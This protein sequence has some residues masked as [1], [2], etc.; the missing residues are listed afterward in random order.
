LSDWSDH[1]VL[2][3]MSRRGEDLPGNLIICEESFARGQELGAVS[4]S[5]NDYSALAEATI[6][7][8]PPGSS[9]GG[10]VPKF[11]SWL[12]TAICLSSLPDVEARA[13]PLRGAGPI[14]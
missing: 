11:V 5:R 6:K 8:H 14:C 10:S 2:L 9:P 7:S 3:A 12:G 13:T 4:R 1:H